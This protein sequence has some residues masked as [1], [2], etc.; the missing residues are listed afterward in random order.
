MKIKFVLIGTGKNA[1]RHARAMLSLKNT[2]LI[3]VFSKSKERSEKFAEKYKIKSYT[4][5]NELL[6]NKEINAID[7]VNINNLH[8]D[9]GILGAK[10]GKHILV[11]K[12]IDVSLEKTEQLIKV[13]EE[14]KVKL[15]VISQHRFDSALQWT[16]KEIEKENLGN[17]IFG[18]ISIKWNRS[19]DYYESSEKWR[20]LNEFSGGG[21]LIIQAIHYID[22]LLWIFGDV[23]SVYGKIDTKLHEIEGE[24]TAVAI[25]KFKSG[26]IAT[27]EATT[28]VV[29]TLKDKLEVHGTKGSIIL[30]GNKVI[31][32]VKTINIEKHQIKKRII[33]YFK[34]KNGF[35][36]DQ[37][38]DFVDSIIYNKEPSI[39]GMDGK[40]ALEVVLSIFKSSNLS[41][42]IILK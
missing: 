42:E 39:T 36:K 5:Y 24:D 22:L 14:N 38:Q 40:K 31:N 21:V 25:L 32:R 17:L 30:E 34:L 28:A 19:K 7:I 33:S 6:K 13:C 11:E 29:K 20:K 18:N 1:H 2:E 27:I 37:I 4:D 9:F 41:K 16:K 15:S 8:G 35:I 3:A 23:K 26:A 12:P 10:A